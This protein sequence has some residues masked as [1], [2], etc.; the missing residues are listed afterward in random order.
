M[1]HWAR[2]L[3][4]GRRLAA[5]SGARVKVVELFAVFHDARRVNENRDPDHGRRGARLATEL[6]GTHFELDDE[7][8]ALLIRACEAHTD[9]LIETDPTIQTCWDADRLD[10]GR[11]GIRPAPRFLGT[12]LARTPGVIAWA[13]ARS[14]EGGVPAWVEAAWGTAPEDPGGKGWARW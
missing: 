1:G 12:P 13:W 10:L 6:R 4:N 11:V 9:S 8:H 3:E 5:A 14:V 7:D 2:V